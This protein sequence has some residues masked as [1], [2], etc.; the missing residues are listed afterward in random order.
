MSDEPTP[1]VLL[2]D[3]VRELFRLMQ[4]SD[5]V[6][7]LIERGETRV[8]LKRAKPVQPVV[9]MVAAPPLTAYAAP[10][11]VA[12]VAAES[13]APTGFTVTSPMVGTFYLAP[14]P[15]DPAYVKLG[16]EVQPGD[17]IGIVEAMKI[18]NEIE[19]EIRGR[20]VELLV[21]NGQAVEY[22]QPLMI[23][24]PS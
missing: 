1:P 23:I 16:D 7:M 4:T 22:G 9:N 5:L 20:V 6:E 17:V 21:E 10:P 11:P 24:E 13:A 12:A 14:S 19:A 3:E 18:M 8:H 15:K 2:T